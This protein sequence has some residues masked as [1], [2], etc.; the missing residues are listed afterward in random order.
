MR[1]TIGAD[2]KNGPNPTTNKSKK[3]LTEN[4]SKF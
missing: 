4:E 2:L 3:L 1:N